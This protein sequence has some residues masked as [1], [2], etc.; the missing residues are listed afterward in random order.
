MG[1]L[2]VTRVGQSTRSPRVLA[3]LA[4]I[5]LRAVVASNRVAMREAKAQGR[6]LPPLYR[7]G[8]VYKVEPWGGRF[9]EFADVLTMLKRGWGD[10]DD[11][12]GY[13]VAELQEQGVN[14]DARL[15]WRYFKDGQLVRDA[16]LL[17]QISKTKRMPAGVSMQMHCQV[18]MPDGRIEDPSRFLGL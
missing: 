7:S 6:P 11:L 4:Q 9:E 14:A 16:K 18:R 3:E 8:I 12:C 13:R 5:F 10:C 15:Y 2:L 1:F 17:E